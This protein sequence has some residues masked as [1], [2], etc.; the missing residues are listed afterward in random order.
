[1]RDGAGIGDNGDRSFN[2][3]IA[4]GLTDMLRQRHPPTE[5]NCVTFERSLRHAII[6]ELLHGDART[7]YRDVCGWDDGGPDLRFGVDYQPD[8]ILELSLLANV[9]ES[10]VRSAALPLKTR[11]FVSARRVLVGHG[12]GSKLVEIY[13]P[14][15]G[16]SLADERYRT[17]QLAAFYAWRDGLT[18]EQIEIERAYKVDWYGCLPELGQDKV[19]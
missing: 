11:M 7:C 16:P 17:A 9:H 6:E 15:W 5:D 19:R 4:A 3:V 13:G 10:I 1:L 18:F 2:G 14:A 12:Y 8:P